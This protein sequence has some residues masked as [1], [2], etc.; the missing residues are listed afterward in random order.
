[1][2]TYISPEISVLSLCENDIMT[3]SRVFVEDVGAPSVVIDW[4]ELN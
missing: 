2:K 4:G 1:M 3:T